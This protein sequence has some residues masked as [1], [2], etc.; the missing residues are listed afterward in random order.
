MRIISGDLGGRL[1]QVPKSLKA[2]P[3]TDRAREALI[4]I[5]RSRIE[6]EEVSALD[7]F[8]GTGIIGFELVS[9]GC[10]EVVSVENDPV[11]CK[12]IKENIRLLGI[13]NMQVLQTDVFRLLKRAYQPYDLIFAD[14]PYDLPNIID[15]PSMILGKQWLSE[16]G[17]FI[18]EHGP[19]V[20]TSGL[21]GFR[22]TR[23]YGK[24]HFSFFG[25]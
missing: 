6:P 21:K 4:N 8:A 2:R 20:K 7:L 11:H 13:N 10:K 9:L 22:E 25:D 18:L 1:I 17:M 16:G 12:S 5:L 14:P 23:N 3:T 15:I 24:V 19:G